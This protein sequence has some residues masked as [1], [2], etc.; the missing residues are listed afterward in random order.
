[1]A[2]TKAPTSSDITTVSVEPQVI[3]AGCIETWVPS[4]KVAGNQTIEVATEDTQEIGGS[5]FTKVYVKA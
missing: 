4:N 2:R 5:S 3:P 1:M